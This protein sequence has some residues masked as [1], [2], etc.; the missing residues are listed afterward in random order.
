MKKLTEFVLER[1]ES[2]FVDEQKINL[3]AI[4]DNILY[5]PDKLVQDYSLT[6]GLTALILDT[7]SKW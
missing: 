5:D 6:D 7:I 1:I 2:Y 3:F 4:V